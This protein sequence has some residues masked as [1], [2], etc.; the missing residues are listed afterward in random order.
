[1]E[2]DI[3]ISV[4]VGGTTFESSVLNKNYLNILD[5]SPK[6]HVKKYSD[7]ESL[8]EGICRQIRDLLNKNDISD[9]RIY[10][11]SVACPGPLDSKNG[12]I[13]NTPNLKLFRNYAL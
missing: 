10:G 8:L 5:M 2:K 12:I 4:D 13:L 1:M 9:S 11:L 7:S 6:W 3:I